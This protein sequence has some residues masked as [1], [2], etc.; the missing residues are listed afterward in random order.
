LQSFSGNK[1]EFRRDEE[2]STQKGQYQHD[3]NKLRTA[4]NS[5]KFHYFLPDIQRPNKS[6]R[7]WNI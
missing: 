4:R 2:D 1:V 5:S 3:N 6:P 7:K